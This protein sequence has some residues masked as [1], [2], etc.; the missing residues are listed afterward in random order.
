MSDFLQAEQDSLAAAAKLP[1]VRD[2]RVKCDRCGALGRPHWN[3]ISRRS[4]CEFP[5]LPRCWETHNGRPNGQIVCSDCMGR[6][7]DSAMAA[8]RAYLNTP[9]GRAQLEREA[10][11]EGIA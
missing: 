10:M 2:R 5:A 6:A 3:F 9:R 11:E 8:M 4:A 1:G 7:M